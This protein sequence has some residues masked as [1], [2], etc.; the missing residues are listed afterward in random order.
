MKFIL[1]KV[2]IRPNFTGTVPNFD[3]RSRENYE[4]SWDAELSLYLYRIRIRQ[5]YSFK[6][7]MHQIIFGWGSAPGPTGGAYNAPADPLVGCGARYPLPVLLS[8]D[9]CKNVL[10]LNFT[11]N[12]L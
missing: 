12:H 3:G 9:I 5:T 6:L 1:H 4:V 2:T 10:V 8:L 11:C 7:R